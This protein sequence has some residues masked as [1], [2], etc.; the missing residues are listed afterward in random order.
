MPQICQL[1]HLMAAWKKVR[2]NKGRAGVDLVTVQQFERH[3][4]AN[5]QTLGT[6]LREDRYYPMPLKRFQVPKPDGTTRPLAILTVEDRIVQRAVV[7]ALE[8]IFEAAFLD[9]SFG[10]RPGRSV[11]DAIQRVQQYRAKGYACIVDGDI[12]DF[13]GSLDHRLLMQF[14]AEHIKDKQVLR[15]IQMWLDLG[16]LQ[17]LPVASTL[18]SLLTVGD[19]LKGA[20]STTVDHLIES[21]LHR[22]RATVCGMDPMGMSFAPEA[23][24][25]DYRRDL[26]REYIRRLGRDGLLLLLTYG[27]EAK[28]LCTPWGLGLTASVVLT[29]VAAPAVGRALATRRHSP[30]GTVQGAVL[31]PLLANAYLHRFDV[32][33][34]KQGYALVRFGDDFVICCPNE[35]RAREA[36][37]AARR[38]LAELRLTLH[39]TKTR[40]VRF[41]DGFTFLGHTFG[42]HG[43]NPL[44]PQEARMRLAET[45]QWLKQRTHASWQRRM[46]LLRTLW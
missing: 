11:G 27:K 4:V 2:A 31:S 32:P 26:R 37:E 46:A 40:L 1:E 18:V 35:A 23:D 10:Y 36:L 9:C 45:G 34:V 7:D 15:L 12:R 24:L 8:P 29:T 41:D 21:A 43:T 6:L 20:F 33:M 38:R 13:F 44:P 14:L 39:P 28:R 22:E 25:D 17:P 3:L 42:T 16:A 30:L 5:L 19:R